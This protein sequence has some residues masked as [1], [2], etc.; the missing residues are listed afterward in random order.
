MFL[1][2]MD[3]ALCYM[4]FYFGFNDLRN[5]LVEFGVE[6]NGMFKQNLHMQVMRL[7]DKSAH[8]GI[9]IERYTKRIIEIFDKIKNCKHISAQDPRSLT[10]KLLVVNDGTSFNQVLRVCINH[11]NNTNLKIP[12]RYI[13]RIMDPTVLIG[14]SAGKKTLGK[15][16]FCH[17]DNNNKR[18]SQNVRNSI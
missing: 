2:I 15:N 5:L 18:K 14:D 6:P 12:Y 8:I 3:P 7:L 13:Q 1:E 9:N 16:I 4:L 11:T 10:T 17:N